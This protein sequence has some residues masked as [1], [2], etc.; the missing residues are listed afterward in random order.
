[1]PY[2]LWTSVLGVAALAGIAMLGARM[3]ERLLPAQR[4]APHVTGAALLLCWH[5]IWAA[6]SGMETAIFSM[7]TLLLIWLAW[8]QSDHFAL[9]PD[10]RIAL[11][12][13]LFGIAAALTTLARPEGI[14]AAGFACLA[15]LMTWI[16]RNPRAVSWW[17]ICG[18]AGF[19]L[20]IA[21]YLL[22][23]LQLTGG[24]LPDTANAKFVQH[25]AL[26]E[27]PYL[28]R[29]YKLAEAIFAGGQILLLPGI[30]AFCWMA[31]QR[32]FGRDGLVMLPL[33][34]SVGLIGL[35][36]ARLPAWYQHGRYVIPAL[37]ALVICGV[38][39]MLWLLHQSSRRRVGLLWRVGVR[40][41]ML[42]TALLFGVFAA[43]GMEIF[44]TDVSII[45]SEMVAAARWIGANVPA[46]E[47]LA[48][49][50][51]GAVGYFAPRPMLD[52][53]GLISPEVVPMLHDP[54][55]VWAYLRQRDARYLMAFADQIPG[56]DP[57]DA[58]MCEI[59]STNS[60]VTIRA[61]GSNMKVYRLVWDATC[62]P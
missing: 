57:A 24:L 5:L 12:G 17:M 29:L 38:V 50:D 4:Y 61:G 2:L 60:E 52:I 22:L 37:P 11:D 13:A 51:I 28:T 34:W 15:L 23:N 54:E 16:R 14:L 56:G 55:Q 18:A 30:V 35:Y 44:R 43:W 32:M 6:S 47:L 9:T 25:A 40:A 26:T 8:V 1:M 46:D 21:P 36:A 10:R 42:S 58:R 48:I 53:A 62:N 3:A 7:L 59:F 49:H 19:L 31:W 45:D 41:L 20:L 27:L 33:A 39:G